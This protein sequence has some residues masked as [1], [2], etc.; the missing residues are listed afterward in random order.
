MAVKD[1]IL[2]VKCGTTDPPIVAECGDYDDWFRNHLA[3]HQRE[4]RTVRPYLGDILPEPTAFA[5]VMVTGSP[6]SVRDE[7][8]WMAETGTWILQ[9]ASQGIPVLAVCFGLQLTIE[10]LGGRVDTNPNGREVGSIKVELTESGK[11]DP[12][13]KGLPASTSFFATHA[14]AVTRAPSHPNLTAL[15][16]NA[17]THWQAFGLGDHLRAVQFHPEMTIDGMQ[18]LLRCRGLTA[19]VEPSSHGATLIENWLTGWVTR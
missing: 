1:P 14:D 4:S 15:A 6:L 18:T 13:F 9:T 7:A 19:H 8:P 5:G 11:R 12:L 17:N 10:A 3:L 2:L 16:G